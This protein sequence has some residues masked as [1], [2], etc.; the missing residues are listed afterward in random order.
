MTRLDVPPPAPSRATDGLARDTELLS[1]T[2]N[3]VLEEQAGRVFASRLQ[4]LFRTA[5]AV[6][7]GDASATDRLVGYLHGVPDESIEP[8][9]RACSL[10]IQLANITAERERLRRRR[11]H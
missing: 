4:W 2:V 8:I 11:Q 6:R 7:G 1:E 3:D 10:E 5:A 9:I